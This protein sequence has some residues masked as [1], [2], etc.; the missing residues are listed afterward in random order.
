MNKTQRNER[1]D[2]RRRGPGIEEC[3]L[4]AG[5]RLA[6]KPLKLSERAAALHQEFTY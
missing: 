2:D 5:T 1:M 6:Q 4:Q 3:V